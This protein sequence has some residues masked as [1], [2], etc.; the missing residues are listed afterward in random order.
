MALL[1]DIVKETA[2]NFGL[3]NRAGALVA[4][5]VRLMFS[6]RQ[7]GL[8]GFLNAFDKAGLSELTRSWRDVSSPVKPIDGKQLESAIGSSGISEAGKKLGMANARVRTAMAFAIPQLVRLIC[9]QG[10][11]PKDI[12]SPIRAFMDSDAAKVIAPAGKPVPTSKPRKSRAWLWW[13]LGTLLLL[14]TALVTGL[15]ILKNQDKIKQYITH[16]RP[17]AS[18]D[19]PVQS[20]QEPEPG[21]PVAKLT[22]R[23]DGGRFE[24]RGEV[25]D[26]G[27][28]ANITEQLL[29]FFGQARLDGNLTI[30]P[31]I[32]VPYWLSKLDRILP[33]LNVPGLDLRLEG[34]TV[35]VGGWLSDQ[36]RESVMSSLKTALGPGFRYGFLGNEEAELA[37]EAKARTLSALTALPTDYR[38][39]DLANVLNRYV[40]LFPEG[41][42]ALPETA[43]EFVPRAAEMM[44]KMSQPVVFEIAGH[45]DNQGNAA[46]NLKLSQDRAVAV[47][48]ALMQ[49]GVPE[50]MLQARGYG[51]DRPVASNE[52]ALGRFKNRRIEFSVLQVCAQRTLCGLPEPEA[53]QP[54]GTTPLP[55]ASPEAA[56]R[57]IE[58]IRSPA[59]DS[60]RGVRNRIRESAGGGDDRPVRNRARAN[61]ERNPDGGDSG[62]AARSARSATDSSDRSGG[63]K[64]SAPKGRWIPQLPKSEPRKPAAPAPRAEHKE[65]AKPKSKPAERKPSAGGAQDLF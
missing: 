63:A 44:K 6:P 16:P 2:E 43:K 18:V 27:M 28:K 5:T 3:G 54:E 42:A 22:I 4:E 10:V 30:D 56:E 49:A 48:M 9:A 41:S 53:A 64:A 40:M 50:L 20:I 13:L 24:Y 62:R 17:T 55:L 46:A 47:K 65:A 21:K 8:Q 7:G 37:L 31:Q 39:P 45:T 34:N 51:A 19:K 61:R 26:I 35:R 60:E 29:T 57:R 38:G 14:G 52:T 12:P 58:S 23:N 59:D 25:S 15:Q 36:D 1:S 11:V 32:A 33:Q